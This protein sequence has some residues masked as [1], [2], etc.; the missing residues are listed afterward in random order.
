MAPTT[1]RSRLLA[2]IEREQRR[3]EAGQ[4]A[5]IRAKMNALVD[6]DDR[7]GRCIARR[8]PACASS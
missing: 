8:R 1:L 3:A 4:P 5:R 6:V 2:L 7:P